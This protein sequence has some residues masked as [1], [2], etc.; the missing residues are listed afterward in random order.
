MQPE[1]PSPID[2]R[3]PA[4][5]ADWAQSAL[6]KRPWRPEFFQA[7]ADTILKHFP[8]GAVRILEL[9]SGPGFLAEHLLQALP[10]SQYVALDFSAAM[11]ALARQC[12]GPGR[13]HI[14]FI[15]R[16]FLT[17]DWSQGL[18]VFDVVVTM[19]A[20]HELRHKT[21]ASALHQQVKSLL[22]SDGYYLLCD[23]HTDTGGMQ[24]T[25]LYMSVSEQKSAL[26][27]AGFT[28]VEQIL[29]KGGMALHQA[30]CK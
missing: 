26:M 29:N 18:G 9:G 7:F 16:N 4:T 13:E 11:H 17:P 20:V 19:Q 24:N 3:D 2:L 22:Q 23:H 14:H 27:T 10:E 25:E 12:V 5:A 30:H 15:E 21:R 8:A 1:I 6:V 28:H